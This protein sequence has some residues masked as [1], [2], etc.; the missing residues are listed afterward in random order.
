M[1]TA[2][3]FACVVV[4][5]IFPAIASASV[6]THSFS[7]S[8]NLVVSQ[9]N[10]YEA[11]CDGDFSFESGVL[12]DDTAIVLRAAGLLTI[13]HQA[14]LKSPL[15]TLDA[16]RLA[17]FGAVNTSVSLSLSPVVLPAL[18]PKVVFAINVKTQ[19]GEF[20]L[21]P[22]V[23]S[24]AILTTG[25]NAYLAGTG[26]G[27]YPLLN[28]NIAPTQGGTLVLSNTGGAIVTMG[29]GGVKVNPFMLA[30]VPEPSN[31]SML[32]MGLLG[33]GLVARRKAKQH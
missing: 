11:S 31:L 2:S 16:D 5:A 33:I 15:I 6:E 8:S 10:G 3:K 23:S 25:N 24:G 19:L 14:L 21:I 12:E 28:G 4:A 32:A 13:G 26:V 18:D 20:Q 22:E 9:E 7:C 27:S 29:A 30:S 17:L 1:K